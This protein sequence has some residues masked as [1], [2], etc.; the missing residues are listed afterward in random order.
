MICDSCAEDVEETS[1]FE[2]MDVCPEC[3]EHFEADEAMRDEE[4]RQMNEA[5]EAE[6]GDEE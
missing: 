4:L 5:F 2:G 6:F 3:R 1:R